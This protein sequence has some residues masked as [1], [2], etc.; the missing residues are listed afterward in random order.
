LPSCSSCAGR[1]RQRERGKGET[2]RP[3]EA[4]ASGNGSL[5]RLLLH[6]D[7]ARSAPRRRNVRWSGGGRPEFRRSSRR[8]N[9]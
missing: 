6:V 2:H 8:L 5:H 1:P 9:S 3:H 4:G 7:G